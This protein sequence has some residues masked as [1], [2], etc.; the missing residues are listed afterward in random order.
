MNTEVLFVE[1]EKYEITPIAIEDIRPGDVIARMDVER[2]NSVKELW[3]GTVSESDVLQWEHGVQYSSSSSKLVT[4]LTDIWAP[5]TGDTK[6]NR[7]LTANPEDRPNKVPNSTKFYSFRKLMVTQ[8]EALNEA[9]NKAFDLITEFIAQDPEGAM[10]LL[11]D[12]TEHT[13]DWL[14]AHN[15]Y[16]PAKKLSSVLFHKS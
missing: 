5:F 16:V 12:D 6:L 13:L 11:E 8:Q 10:E 4:G 14:R 3:V 7:V 2:N 1:S 9:W 15:P